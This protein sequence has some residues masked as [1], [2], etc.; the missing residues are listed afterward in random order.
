MLY[1]WGHNNKWG[2]RW[3]DGHRKRF[4]I[5]F[6]NKIMFRK[7]IHLCLAIALGMACATYAG[8]YKIGCW[9]KSG[10]YDDWT[11][12]EGWGN[13][14]NTVL[15]PGV[16]TGVT[17]GKG[18]LK[19]ENDLGW[20]WGIKVYVNPAQFQKNNV[21]KID[22]TRLAADWTLSGEPNWNGLD[23]RIHGQGVSFEDFNDGNSWWSP[24][25]GDGPITATWDYSDYK[26]LFP[27]N[28]SWVEF[29]IAFDN[30]GYTNP[31]GRGTFY[32]D[33]ARLA[34]DT[35]ETSI[36]KC[37]IKAGKTQYAELGPEDD[38]VSKMKDSFA[39]SGSIPNFI[40]LDEIDNVIVNLI[41]GDDEIIYTEEI[42]PFDYLNTA[43]RTFK[44]S[45][46]IPRGEEG[47]ITSFKIDF[48][49]N[50]FSIK[51]QNLDLTGLTCP[52]TLELGIGDVTISA[53][54]DETIIN[55]AKK[56][57]PIRLM[58]MYADT[59]RITKAKAKAGTTDSFAVKGEIAVETV[60]TIDLTDE[61]M[62][63]SWGDTQTFTIPAGSFRQTRATARVYKCSK[64]MI[65]DG[66]IAT[67]KFDLDKCKFNI[68][69]KNAYLD[70]TSGAVDFGISFADFDESATLYLP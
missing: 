49:K 3:Q 36:E 46:K 13:Y 9:E 5:Q 34:I 17:L 1:I 11:T 21:F 54:A 23:F 32:L 12:C 47:A 4:C 67:C 65:D 26:D 2:L 39:I 64:V 16:T 19:V 31:S 56:K 38:D 44:Y 69:I 50:I 8:D 55:G 22:I 70:E 53:T 51:A 7:Q 20:Y 43:R 57:I 68:S 27:K 59:L 42:D 14:G 52:V 33:N 60:D 35:S 45:Y 37:I 61:E 15:T 63:I 25:D 62:V 24:S 6:G 66:A 48:N 18:A 10:K 29:V 40:N 28:Q 30:K 58:R 41:S